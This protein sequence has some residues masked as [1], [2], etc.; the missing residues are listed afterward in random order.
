MMPQSWEA[1]K[2]FKAKNF[3]YN[4]EMLQMPLSEY[5]Y[6]DSTIVQYD[7]VWWMISVLSTINAHFLHVL[8]ADSPI[9]PW[10]HTPHNCYVD[11]TYQN[12]LNSN[13][14]RPFIRCHGDHPEEAS[15][16]EG[17]THMLTPHNFRITKKNHPF[18]GFRPGGS[19]FEYN[20][21]LFRMVQGTHGSYGDVLDVYEIKRLSKVLPM[22]EVKI[23]EFRYNLLQHHH[24]HV[25][26]GTMQ[27]PIRPGDVNE[28]VIDYWNQ[29]RMHHMDLK[30]V[31][32]YGG[33]AGNDLWV[34]V[35][36]GDSDVE[37][38]GKLRNEAKH[39][40]K[41]LQNRH[42]L[43]DFDYNRYWKFYD[44]CT[45]NRKMNNDFK[46]SANTT[47]IDY[48][49]LQIEQSLKSITQRNEELCFFSAASSNHY[50]E[51][52]VFILHFFEM[53]PCRTLYIYDL[54]FS[55]EEVKF[56]KELPNVHVVEL[57]MP[58]GYF[59][60]KACVF[61][62]FMLL[63]IVDGYGSKHQCKEFFYGDTSIVLRR[64]FD[65]LAFNEL[66]RVGIVAES[67]QV[68]P[69]IEMTHP[70]MYE[71]FGID[72]DD[73][74]LSDYEANNSPDSHV[75][76]LNQVQAGLQL[77]STLNR[78]MRNE[79]YVPWMKCAYD[80]TKCLSP[81]GFKTDYLTDPRD[82]YKVLNNTV[83]IFRYVLGNIWRR[84]QCISQ[85]VSLANI[86]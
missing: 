33:I 17:S 19:I 7:G 47:F 10:K 59:E 79:F 26:M 3:P 65:E 31:S 12:G 78:R 83:K 44:R 64:Q 50:K 55:E 57:H 35:M 73:S 24:K 62:P 8:Y 27:Y 77:V 52:M 36:D 37:K 49:A 76:R 81:G 41:S 2:L 34:G 84:Y 21:K 4:W 32:N 85:S 29:A 18:T 6:I 63:D 80:N 74:Y 53:Y 25:Q 16:V 30:F 14:V 58:R 9:G 11:D 46:L 39:V 51:L 45:A 82:I 42:E 75:F 48:Q 66:D 61:K 56:L 5:N 20:K 13:D 86:S 43:K 71:Y 40:I 70:G 68:Y 22:Q 69:Q 1:Q 38:G 23:P 60:Y 15:I 28:D 72:R 67:P 54:G